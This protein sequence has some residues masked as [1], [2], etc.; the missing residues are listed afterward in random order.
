MAY[1]STDKDGPGAGGDAYWLLL[2]AA[3]VQI[4]RSWTPS[5]QVD[6]AADD[7]DKTFTVP[8]NTEW[9][10]KWIYLEFTTTADAGTRQMEIQIQDDAADVI[11]RLVCGDTQIA[12][13]TRY[14]LFAPN[15]AELTAERDTDK[16]STL[17]PE[18]F[19]P[20]GYVIRIWDNKAI[21]AGADDLVAQIMVGTRSV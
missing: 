16:F 1:G 5:L 7:S 12:S 11:A 17:M 13:L 20:A 4:T 18:W 14:Y 6:E 2:N 10:V 21:Q 19:L 8:A 3:G 15:V 9:L